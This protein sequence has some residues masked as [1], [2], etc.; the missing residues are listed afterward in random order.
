M[1]KTNF[2]DD[3]KRDA[4]LQI[5]ERGYP[6]PEVSQ[7]LGV[8]PYSLYAWKKKF[9]EP[10]G[11][12][13]KD[14]EI[15]RLKR[16]LTRVTEERDTLKSHRVF[17][18]GCKVR[19]AFIAEHRPVFS[20][21]AMCRCLRIH[22]SGFYAWLK[23]PQSQRARKDVRKTEFIRQARKNSGKVCG[24]RQLHDDL[25]DQGETCCP[26]RVARL[27]RMAGIKARIG[28][29]R[30]SKKKMNYCAARVN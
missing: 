22:P 9:S 4:V 30:I 15:R 2:S 28:Y 23:D 11:G 21:R 18:H 19:Y 10:S 8:S 7:R 6:V 16:E 27:A 17:R 20:V 14:G 24:Y 3:F 12:G 29:K 25:L 1:G 26:N 5:T 13:D